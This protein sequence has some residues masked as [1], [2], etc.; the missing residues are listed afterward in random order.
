MMQISDDSEHWRRLAE[1]ARIEA[2]QITNPRA[3]QMML[4]IAET[5][6]AMARRAEKKPRL[7]NLSDNERQ[8][9]LD[10]IN[11]CCDQAVIACLALRSSFQNALS[12]IGLYCRR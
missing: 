9:A 2:E 5:Y 7:F 11:G 3:K 12:E 8:S 10:L 1:E 4:N 6:D